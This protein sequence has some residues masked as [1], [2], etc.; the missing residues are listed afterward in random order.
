MVDKLYAKFMDTYEDAGEKT[1]A[2]LQRLQVALNL[3]V[4]RGGV[5]AADLNRHLLTQLCRS[6]WDN[7][8]ISDLQLKQRKANPLS[9]PELLLLIHT[10]E[11]AKTHEAA[12]TPCMKQHLGVVKQ[13][14]SSQ[15]QVVYIDEGQGLC[16]ALTT[17]T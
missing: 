9:S 13:R 2:F 16:A 1:F 3:A 17:P 8:L 14:V 11:A 6:C 10:E 12:K 5:S 4:K 7:S 15:S